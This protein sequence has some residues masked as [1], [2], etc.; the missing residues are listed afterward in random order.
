MAS[1]DSYTQKEPNYKVKIFNGVY[2]FTASHHS[3]MPSAYDEYACG[4]YEIPASYVGIM[5][6]HVKDFIRY[7]PTAEFELLEEEKH[8]FDMEMIGVET[9][10]IVGAPT[11]TPTSWGGSEEFILVNI[12]TN[13]TTSTD[14]TGTLTVNGTDAADDALN[15]VVSISGTG[16]YVCLNKFKTVISVSAITGLTCNISVYASIA[17]AN[18]K[19]EIKIMCDS[20]GD[21]IYGIMFAGYCKPSRMTIMSTWSEVTYK[22]IGYAS[23]LMSNEYIAG[24]RAEK[25]CS[26]YSKTGEEGTCSLSGSTAAAFWQV[27]GKCYIGDFNTTHP[28]GVAIAQALSRCTVYAAGT[29]NLPFDRY[30]YDEQYAGSGEDDYTYYPVDYYRAI[31]AARRMINSIDTG[32]PSSRPWGMHSTHYALA[33]GA[34]TDS[35]TSITY[36]NHVMQS[37]DTFTTNSYIHIEDEWMKVSADTG[38]V[39]TVVRGALGSN[40]VAHSDNSEIFMDSM[41]DTFVSVFVN[42]TNDMLLEGNIKSTI[43]KY[44]ESFADLLAAKYTNAEFVFWIDKFKQ[45]RITEMYLDALGSSGIGGSSPLAIVSSNIYKA[46]NLQKTDVVNSVSTFIKTSSGK[47]LYCH[48]T[49]DEVTNYDHSI[50]VFGLKSKEITNKQLNSVGVDDLPNGLLG[51]NTYATAYLKLHS[52]PRVTQ[53]ITVDTFVPDEHYWTNGYNPLFLKSDYPN[54]NI[55]ILGSQVTCPDYQLDAT[56]IKTFIIE[57]LEYSI[58]SYGNFETKITMSRL[59]AY[60]EY[61]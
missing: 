8:I 36:D 24:Y 28:N 50:K 39:L 30:T 47:K 41:A 44:G 45:L 12:D 42:D 57:G 52:F 10:S 5:K 48:M 35:A 11:I 58:N 1:F 14:T 7:A 53:T 6:L 21:G 20:T 54:D 4:W 61:L 15:E 33:N 22:G 27:P 59:Q 25:R 51:F 31:D 34:I 3:N 56:P 2:D 40:A 19:R 46:T 26:N 37:S 13:G 60:G 16:S 29:E 23:E 55:D 38:T 17:P 18:S 9:P 32:M 49:A 43:Y